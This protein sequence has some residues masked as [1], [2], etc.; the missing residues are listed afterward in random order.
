MFNEVATRVR[1]ATLSRQSTVLRAV[2]LMLPALLS[3]RPLVAQEFVLGSQTP[4][5]Q[6]LTSQAPTEDEHKADP[7]AAVPVVN[8]LSGKSLMFPNLAV[9]NKR[10]TPKQKFFL[11]ADNSVSGITLSAQRQALAPVRRAIPKPATVRVQKAI[12]NV[13]GSRHGFRCHQQ[14]GRHICHRFRP[15]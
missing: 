11:A 6:S 1:I 4:H 5:A 8:L 3:C 2:A 12:L 10:L 15:A 14:H 7:R 13:G 9:N